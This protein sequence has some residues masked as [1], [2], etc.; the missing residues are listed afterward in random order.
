MMKEMK[1]LKL[2]DSFFT[3]PDLIQFCKN[4]IK[5]GIVTGLE[6]GGVSFYS[7]FSG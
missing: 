4:E 2:N 5:D 7:R 1:G 3:V 6:I